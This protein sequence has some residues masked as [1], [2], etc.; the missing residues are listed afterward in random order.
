MVVTVWIWTRGV[1]AA[2]FMIGHQ[3]IQTPRR[4]VTEGSIISGYVVCRRAS[5]TRQFSLVDVLS[6]C[7]VYMI[8]EKQSNC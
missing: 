6:M 4:F 5:D 7:T 2:W 1:R 3:T 8:N